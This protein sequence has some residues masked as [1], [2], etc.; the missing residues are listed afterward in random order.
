[1]KGAEKIEGGEN[2]K[3]QAHALGFI[4]GVGVWQVGFQA[5]EPVPDVF[6]FVQ[7]G[8]DDGSRHSCF[9]ILHTSEIKKE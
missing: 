4:G 9:F 5:A 8:M 3:G 6:L 2:E 1:M 7:G